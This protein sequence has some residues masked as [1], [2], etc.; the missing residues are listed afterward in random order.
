MFVHQAVGSVVSSVIQPPVL[1]KLLVLITEWLLLP[2][3]LLDFL[4]RGSAAQLNF[5][6]TIY[7]VG[8]KN[9]E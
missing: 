9:V 8:Q 7:I 3:R 5:A 6:H 4:G 2:I 1:A